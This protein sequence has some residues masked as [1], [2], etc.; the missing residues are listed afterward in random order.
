MAVE[1]IITV[2]NIVFDGVERADRMDVQPATAERRE[3]SSI[4]N[5]FHFQWR[6]SVIPTNGAKWITGWGAVF[7]FPT[8]DRIIRVLVATRETGL[9]DNDVL[10]VAR[11]TEL[12]EKKL[13]TR[14]PT[15]T[16]C[17]LDGPPGHNVT[18]ARH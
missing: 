15:P 11:R 3:F 8:I 13:H 14:G 7:T 17:L 18:A 10:V 5:I 2:A 12:S 6:V 1:I 9:L 16:V 4:Q